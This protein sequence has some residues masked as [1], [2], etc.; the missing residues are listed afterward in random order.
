MLH[1]HELNK[2]LGGFTGLVGLEN[3]GHPSG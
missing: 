3:F 1:H 2:Q